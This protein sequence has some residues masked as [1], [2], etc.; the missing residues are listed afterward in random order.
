MTIFDQS[1]TLFILFLKIYGIW[2][3]NRHEVFISFVVDAVAA[4]AI[5]QF[6]FEMDSVTR[7]E[8]ECL[9]LQIGHGFQT[10]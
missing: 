8:T 9:F 3:A 6:L 1:E 7:C 2:L 10:S 5:V 4:V